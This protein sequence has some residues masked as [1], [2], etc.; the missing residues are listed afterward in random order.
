M[1]RRSSINYPMMNVERN[2]SLLNTRE[3]LLEPVLSS[4]LRVWFKQPLTETRKTKDRQRCLSTIKD[5]LNLFD[6]EDNQ[7]VEDK[8]L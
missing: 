7:T 1:F 8:S 5:F 4:G 2:Q 6:I 3:T